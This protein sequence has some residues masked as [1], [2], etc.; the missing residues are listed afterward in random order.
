MKTLSD[1]FATVSVMGLAMMIS[2]SCSNV[3]STSTLA[4]VRFFG[5]PRHNSPVPETASSGNESNLAKSK[6]I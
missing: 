5:F 2:H 6:L 4:E 3:A 1:I